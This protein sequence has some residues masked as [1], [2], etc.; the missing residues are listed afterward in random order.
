MVSMHITDFGIHCTCCLSFWHLPDRHLLTCRIVATCVSW[1]PSSWTWEELQLDL[2]GQGKRRLRKTWLKPWQSS[3][4]SSTALMDSTTRCNVATVIAFGYP[5]NVNISSEIW[6]ILKE[7]EIGLLYLTWKEYLFTSV[8][9]S[10]HCQKMA[11][12][13]KSRSS[14]RVTTVKKNYKSWSAHQWSTKLQLWRINA[15]W[16]L[17][18]MYSSQES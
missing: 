10:K 13:E 4:W 15:I 12:G 14:R 11:L 6:F 5:S 2:Q 9:K 18:E 17:A 16:N 3:V 8:N 1:E 7:K